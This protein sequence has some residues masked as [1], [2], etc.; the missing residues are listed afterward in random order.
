M[1]C[2]G[3]L[4]GTRT[5]KVTVMWLPHNLFRNQTTYYLVVCISWIAFLQLL[6]PAVYLTT[7]DTPFLVSRFS[8]I[9]H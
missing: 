9:C 4:E 2:A 5:L 1:R 3:F 7:K 8:H 6:A